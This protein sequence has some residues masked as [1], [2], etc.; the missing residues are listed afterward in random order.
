MKVV[1]FN[2]SP[3][4]NGVVARGIS[5]V[6][7][8]LEKEGM[9]VETVHVGNKVIRGCIAC[10]ACA[11]SKRCIIN[12][13]IVNECAEKLASVDGIILGSPVYF[14]SIAGNFKCFLDRLFFPRPD[15]KYKV[16]ATVVSLRRTGGVSTFHQIN[17][18]FNL[19]QM[20]ITPGMYWEVIHGTKAEELTQDEEGIQIMQVQGRNMA[21][22]IKA[23]AS[24]R[25]DIPLPTQQERK[26]T[27]FIH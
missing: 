2:G 19:S 9:S 8:E 14:G 15:L 11:N 4:A 23:L 25:K 16:G 17:N 10:G 3:H 13:D 21:W 12:D 1:A 26:R 18:Y 24:G 7:E 27:N 6:K 5:I 20:V 22:L